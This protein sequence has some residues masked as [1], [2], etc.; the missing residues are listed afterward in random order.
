[1]QRLP[2][3]VSI[4][5]V[6]FFIFSLTGNVLIADP[7]LT[8]V[9]FADDKKGKK[10]EKNALKGNKRLRAAVSDLQGRVDT[11]ETAPPVPGV[12]GPQGE[13]GI[14]G[15]PGNDGT[16]GLPGAD[17]TVAGPPGPQG[18][19]G[20]Q[21]D[22]GPPGEDGANGLPGADS[23]VAGP[24]GP[25]GIQGI[26]GE[27]GQDGQDGVGG[28]P[29]FVLL[30][31]KGST[32]G[33]ILNFGVLGGS[34][35]NYFQTLLVQIQYVRPSGE[36]INSSIGVHFN[37]SKTA[38]IIGSEGTPNGEQEIYFSEPRCSGQAYM[39]SP[40]LRGYLQPSVT[41]HGNLYVV[42]S[43]VQQSPAIFSMRRESPYSGGFDCVP[44]K[45]NIIK[46]LAPVELIDSNVQSTFPPPY[47]V[48]LAQ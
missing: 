32:I 43:D 36:L 8:S 37:T 5:T 38:K 16:D 4:F 14:Q 26:Q 21:G 3:T 10:K 46:G 42:T 11:L 45:G 7:S 28:G 34:R 35:T 1:V 30:D 19:P 27:S 12:P 6:L 17:S 2:V 39:G 15:I 31:S 41:L 44:F 23:T 24:P 33:N 9:A 22:Q 18:I 47:S 20:S 25:Q 48:E 29:S 40:L 13:Q